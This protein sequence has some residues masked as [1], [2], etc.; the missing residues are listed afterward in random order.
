LTIL[1][2]A[3]GAGLVAMMVF[4]MVS[5]EIGPGLSAFGN[6][7]DYWTSFIGG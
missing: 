5:T 3:I 2:T 1:V 7:I 4:S 6:L